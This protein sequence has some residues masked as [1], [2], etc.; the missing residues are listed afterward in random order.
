M[1]PVPGKASTAGVWRV[2]TPSS[3][4]SKQ[5]RRDKKA[6]RDSSLAAQAP[7]RQP[8]PLTTEQAASARRRY[9]AMKRNAR[10]SGPLTVGDLDDVGDFGNHG[11][12]IYH[13]HVGRRERR[14]SGPRR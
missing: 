5:V 1:P 13:G 10:P 9:Q 3:L 6:Y 14:S 4:R 7:R 11:R 12:V 2:F 8:G